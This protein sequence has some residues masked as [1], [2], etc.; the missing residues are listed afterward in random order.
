KL[1]EISA[2]F[3]GVQPKTIIAVTGTNGKTS[4]TIFAQQLWE[5]AGKKAVSMG[6]IGIHGSGIERDGAMTTPDPVTLHKDLADL[7]E[8]GITHLAIEASSHGLDQYRLDGVNIKAA[9]F[10]NLSRD[11]LDYHPDMEDYLRAKARLFTDLLEEGGVAVLNAD[12]PQFEDLKSKCTNVI[13]YG[14]AGDDYKVIKTV[15]TAYGQD[16]QLQIDGEEHEIHFPFVGEFQLMNA[17]CA[18]GLVSM[19][20]SA[21]DYIHFFKNLKGVPGRLQPVSGHPGGAGIYIDYAHT[22]DAL[23]NVLKAARPHTE[24][25]LICITGCGGDRDKGKRPQMAKMAS[26]LADYAIITDDNPR[27]EDPAAIR[28]DMIA[29]IEKDNFEEVDGRGAAIHKAIHDL[30]KGDVLIIAGKGHEQGIEFADRTEPFDDVQ[31]AEKSIQQLL[32]AK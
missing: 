11:H 13:S 4:T 17:L 15:P 21:N 25:R 19:G 20:K 28:A 14:F 29:G 2:E 26:E 23:E 18:L 3:Y 32:N 16:V 24:N 22:P 9:G 5:M 8:K 7:S 31:E 6:T 30:Q 10:T 27:S 12:A 1:A